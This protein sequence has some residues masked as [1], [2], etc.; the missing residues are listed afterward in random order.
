MQYLDGEMGPSDDF[1]DPAP[2]DVFYAWAIGVIAALAL[3]VYGSICIYTQS[4]TW[5]GGDDLDLALGHV[6]QM[7]CQGAGAVALGIA[8]VATASLLHCHFFWSWRERFHGYAQLGKLLSLVGIAGGM[9]YFCFR[10]WLD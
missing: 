3:A 8:F 2:R 5:V 6:P 10:F 7:H 4:A 1:L 9:I